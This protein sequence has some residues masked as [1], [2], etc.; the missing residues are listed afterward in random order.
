MD[1][2][3]DTFMLGMLVSEM[4]MPC[5]KRASIASHV[6]GESDSCRSAASGCV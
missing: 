5:E 3:A 4:C 2:V 6:G 1:D